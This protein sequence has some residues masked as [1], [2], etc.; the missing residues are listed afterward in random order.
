MA[1][2]DRHRDELSL[3]CDSLRGKNQKANVRHFPRQFCLA[4]RHYEFTVILRT[5]FTSL[6]CRYLVS[7]FLL[8]GKETELSSKIFAETSV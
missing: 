6:P 4:Y 2:A 7:A 1:A 5:I 3:V 8:E